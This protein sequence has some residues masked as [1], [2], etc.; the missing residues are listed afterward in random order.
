VRKLSYVQLLYRLRLGGSRTDRSNSVISSIVSPHEHPHYSPIGLFSKDE[1]DAQHHTSHTTN[2]STIRTTDQ[3]SGD[4]PSDCLA[5][6]GPG[7][8]RESNSSLSAFCHSNKPT[9]TM[10]ESRLDPSPRVLPTTHSPPPSPGVKHLKPNL[11]PSN[12]RFTESAPAN[13]PPPSRRTSLP[14]VLI[15]ETPPHGGGSRI[16]SNL[17]TTEILADAFPVDSRYSDPFVGTPYLKSPLFI[18]YG[19]SLKIA[20]STFVNR[21]FTV[22]DSPDASFTIGERCL[23]GPNVTLAG[24]GH[25]LGTPFYFFFDPSMHKLSPVRVRARPCPGKSP[26]VA[27]LTPRP[28]EIAFLPTREPLFFSF[29]LSGVKDTV[30]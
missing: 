14:A 29:F 16:T 20:P 24:V 15:R 4:V 10:T 30:S 8:A 28:L 11:H 17:Q 13:T 23:I 5:E 12:E 3:T 25:P 2:C 1:T 9:S 26:S 18:D 27:P 6:Q 21:N 22:V 19:T 7:D